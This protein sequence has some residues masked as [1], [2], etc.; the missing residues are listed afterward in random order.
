MPSTIKDV[1]RHAGV[2]VGTVSRV[3]N[4]SPLVSP[5]T[6]AKVRDAIRQLDYVPNTYARRLSLGKT[7]TIG[8]IA[9]WFTRPSVVE[10][11]RGIEQVLSETQYDLN[12]F[13]LETVDR[14]QRCF[15]EIVRQGKVDGLLLVSIMPTEQEA[16]ALKTAGVPTVQID[17]R[18]YYF[19]QVAIDDTVAGMEATNHLIT[20]GHRKIAFV[21][22]F[23][24]V[25]IGNNSQEMRYI[26]YKQGLETIGLPVRTEYSRQCHFQRSS[27]RKVALELFD[28]AD[29]PT[30]IFAASD[31]LAFGI[32]EAALDVG[33]TIPEDLSVIGFDDIE[34]STYLNLTT[35][36]QPLLE[37][38]IQGTKLLLKILETN[39]DKIEKI[40]LPTEVI[41]RGTTGVPSNLLR[42]TKEVM[43]EAN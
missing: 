4:E 38:G 24:S 27:A 34:I 1:A 19:S 23:F 32:L 25:G 10:R 7:L 35:I 5:A 26:G 41:E 37:T 31:T 3:L 39:N 43:P 20:K 33:L 18:G 30:A 2:G 17:A 16:T 22:D 29:P 9:P 11:L 42:P 40:I 8:V 21:S 15:D 28:L 36:R 14:R 6:R 13:N 12:I